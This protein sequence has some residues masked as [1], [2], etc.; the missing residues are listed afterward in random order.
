[1]NWSKALTVVATTLLASGIG[2]L[3]LNVVQGGS[4]LAVQQR[5][6]GAQGEQLHD[7]ELRTRSLEGV[8]YQLSETQKTTA[9]ILERL[10]RRVENEE[11]PKRRPR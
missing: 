10:E 11:A 5:D 8:V 4:V 7:H 9:A 3:V 1:M 6:I 2:W